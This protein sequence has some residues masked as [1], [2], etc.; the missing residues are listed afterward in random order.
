MT[1]AIQNRII[2]G[3]R[4][5]IPDFDDEAYRG[6]LRERFSVASSSELSDRRAEDLVTFLR[7][8]TG[9]GSVQRTRSNTA[10]GKYA[11][12]LRALWIA[13]WNLGEVRSPDDAALIA[14]A[15][16][17]TG[18]AHTQF[19]TD[20]A[21]A[22]RVVEALKDWC[23]RAGVE[24]PEDTREVLDRKA[25]IVRAQVAIIRRQTPSFDAE[26]YGAL[27]GLPPRFD[28]YGEKHFDR[29]SAKLGLMVRAAKTVRT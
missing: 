27:A 23:A 6:V 7:G 21:D 14:F 22:R 29:L 25:A 11:P 5:Q 26:M 16:R 20:W 3:L 18:L 4:R 28:H 8:L 13:L 24:W 9:S 17:Q 15:Q 19:L 2:H 1:T 12:L 10:S